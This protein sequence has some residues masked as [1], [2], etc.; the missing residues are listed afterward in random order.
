MTIFTFGVCVM[1]DKN[2]F[3]SPSVPQL[4]KH[5]PDDLA[6]RALRALC[7]ALPLCLPNLLRLL[8]ISLL[9]GAQASDRDAQGNW[10]AYERT[11]LATCI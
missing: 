11:G 10:P 6:D 8:V 2:S 7:R 3:L 1:G 5:V 9:L 4:A